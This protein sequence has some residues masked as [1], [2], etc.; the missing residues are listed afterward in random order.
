M[1]HI[2]HGQSCDHL[3][4]A[5]CFN[6]WNKALKS[7]QEGFITVAQTI[8]SQEINHGLRLK[9]A[10]RE[11]RLRDIRASPRFP[12]IGHTIDSFGEELHATT[13]SGEFIVNLKMWKRNK[14]N[15]RSLKIS[16]VL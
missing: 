4:N 14:L 6:V 10:T 7:A 1:L 8:S 15:E 16:G 13:A 3:R 11:I 2:F 9:R 5:L 12:R